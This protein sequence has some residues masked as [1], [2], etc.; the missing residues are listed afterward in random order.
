[1]LPQTLDFMFLLAGAAAVVYICL[2]HLGLLAIV[3]AAP[4]PG[5]AAAVAAG[6]AFAQIAVPASPFAWL[7]AMAAALLLAENFARSVIAGTGRLAAMRTAFAA[8]GPTLALAT[9]APLVVLTGLAVTTWQQPAV[10]MMAA[11]LLGAM[12]SVFACMWLAVILPY[13]EDFVAR[14]NRA[15]E[16]WQRL[17][18][19]LID[20]ACPR[21]GF[22]L[23][24]ITLVFAVLGFFGA[25]GS[26]LVVDLRPS[27][28]QFLW[29][30]A[31]AMMAVVTAVLRD[32]RS[33]AATLAVLATAALMGLSWLARLTPP[34]DAITL[35]DIYFVLGAAMLPL[36]TAAA[37]TAG[38]LRQGSDAGEAV[39]QTLTQAGPGSLFASSSVIAAL[40]VWAGYA[41]GF[42]LALA[43]MAVFAGLGVGA[44]QPAL[45]MVLEVWLPRR[46]TIAARYR[47]E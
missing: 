23:A 27:E 32:W 6:R 4:L 12:A 44:F 42:G 24:G 17:I 8:R 14:S 5:L 13:D 21:W 30:D 26:M 25:R 47:I 38:H 2:R 35:V 33:V 11:Q 1:M 7:F 19:P 18:D 40:L 37:E 41:G 31:G 28:V 46:T 45:T 34:L 3:V 43:A 20:L 29:L 36:L 22:A 39:A 9:V 15:W 10:L 16:R